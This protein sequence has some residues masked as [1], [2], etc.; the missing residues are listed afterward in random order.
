[1]PKPKPKPK[2]TPKVPEKTSV[3]DQFN[4]E[5]KWREEKTDINIIIYY[6]FV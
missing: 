6:S 2:A 3:C 5:F 4:C 1:M